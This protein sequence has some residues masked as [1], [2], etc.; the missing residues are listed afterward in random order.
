M[1]DPGRERVS[2]T[3]FGPMFMVNGAPPMLALR[4]RL[5]RFSRRPGITV[6][7]CRKRQPIHTALQ[8]CRERSDYL[9][10]LHLYQ[11]ENLRTATRRL[12]WPCVINRHPNGGQAR[13]GFAWTHN[14]RQ[15]RSSLVM[16]CHQPES[17]PQSPLSPG[18][19]PR[20]AQVPPVQ[21]FAARR[22]L[23]TFTVSLLLLS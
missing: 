10:D 12:L 17:P 1:P 15:S 23:R 13:T 22:P 2:V 4:P 8:V 11:E 9:S 21:T 6:N 16:R 3:P 7:D 5:E 19:Q 20:P 14:V 18:P